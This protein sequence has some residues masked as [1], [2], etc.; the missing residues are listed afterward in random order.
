MPST[1]VTCTCVMHTLVSPTR[2]ASEP[3]FIYESRHIMLQITSAYNSIHCQAT[4][5]INQLKFSPHRMSLEIWYAQKSENLT[6]A[7][8]FCH[9]LCP[10]NSI[11]SSTTTSRGLQC[12]N[13]TFT[14]EFFNSPPPHSNFAAP[15]ILNFRMNTWVSYSTP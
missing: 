6:T 13:C 7:R 12:T 4:P 10:Q 14:Q 9:L 15:C 1:H 8:V 3:L 2:L 11:A 5:A